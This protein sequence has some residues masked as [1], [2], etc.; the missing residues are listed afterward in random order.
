MNL[1]LDTHAFIWYIEGSEELSLIARNHIED[2]QNQCFASI[3]SL[4]EMSI[5]I[6]LGK[7]EM[8]GPFHS[9]LED[10]GGNGFSILSITFTHTLLNIHLNWFHKDPFDRLLIAQSMAEKMSLISRD[11]IFDAYLKKDT[12]KR[13]W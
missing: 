4:W 8:Q 12:V 1:I 10:I 6:S 2:P 7:L 3:V 5:K 11:I 9:I 13:I